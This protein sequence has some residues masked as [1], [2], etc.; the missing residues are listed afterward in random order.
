MGMCSRPGWG[1]RGKTGRE[2]RGAGQGKGVRGSVAS[3]YRQALTPVPGME[4]A[5]QQPSDTSVLNK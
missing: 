2:G 1:K 4:T 5:T 3:V